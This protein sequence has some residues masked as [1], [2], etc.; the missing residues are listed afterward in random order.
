MVFV[1]TIDV[2]AHKADF[3]PFKVRYVEPSNNDRW[4]MR[5]CLESRAD[6]M[7]QLIAYAVKH[8]ISL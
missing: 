6:Y 5:R 3:T 1:C 7:Q 4:E 8:K 2:I